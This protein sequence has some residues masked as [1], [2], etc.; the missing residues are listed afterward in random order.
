MCRRVSLTALASLRGHREAELH[1]HRYGSCSHVAW[2]AACGVWPG[3]RRHLQ[4]RV[5]VWLPGL[6]CYLQGTFRRVLE[7]GVTRNV[8]FSL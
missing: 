4:R 1:C 7:C 3:L 2:I 5:C 8:V 6:R